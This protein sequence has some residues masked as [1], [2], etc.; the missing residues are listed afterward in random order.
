MLNVAEL[1]YEYILKHI[2]VMSRGIYCSAY[3]KSKR[4]KEYC[5]RYKAYERSLIMFFYTICAIL[6]DPYLYESAKS[7]Y[8]VVPQM[9]KEGE[10]IV[11]WFVDAHRYY[12]FSVKHGLVNQTQDFFVNAKEKANSCV[13]KIELMCD[14]ILHTSNFI[15]KDFI[16]VAACVNG[17]KFFLQQISHKFSDNLYAIR[18]LCSYLIS[19]KKEQGFHYFDVE[20]L[21]MQINIEEYIEILRV[22]YNNANLVYQNFLLKILEKK[23][24]CTFDDLL[25]SIADASLNNPNREPFICGTEVILFN[26]YPRVFVKS[27]VKWMDSEVNKKDE[28]DSSNVQQQANDETVLPIETISKVNESKKSNMVVVNP[29][30]IIVQQQTNDKNVLP[31]ETVSKVN[32]SNKSDVIVVNPSSVIVQQLHVETVEDSDP[33]FAV[34]QLRKRSIKYLL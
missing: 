7:A 18:S 32:E 28:I 20:D 12:V 23:Y 34:K 16:Y 15:H 30:S 1:I 25:L 26:G 3:E 21:K 17:I 29:S 27:F 5:G 4:E 13:I 10:R 9:E 22:E 14:Y 8:F 19:I 24:R 6:K 2:T 11:N 31:T 33:I